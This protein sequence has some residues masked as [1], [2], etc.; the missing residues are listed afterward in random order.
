VQ[1]ECVL[2]GE[3]LDVGTVFLPQHPQIDEVGRVWLEPSVENRRQ[4]VTIRHRPHVLEPFANEL[5][6]LRLVMAEIQLVIT[7]EA[8]VSE[9]RRASDDTLII[10]IYQVR[11]AMQK[12]ALKPADFHHTGAQPF[13][14][15]TCGSID[16]MG[17]PEEIAILLE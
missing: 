6:G 1:A 5:H 4:V 11:L 3:S 15:L 14:K 17:E 16:L 7:G 8:R 12:A 13:D 2:A 10:G 9:V